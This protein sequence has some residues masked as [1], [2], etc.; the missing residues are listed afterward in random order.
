MA[1]K[2]RGHYVAQVIIDIE[3]DY[4]DGM[5]PANDIIADIMGDGF[6][7]ALFGF[8]SDIGDGC[9]VAIDKQYAEAHLEEDADE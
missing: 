2:I 1:K 4:E 6:T 8:L 7:D 5:R 9:T 3:T